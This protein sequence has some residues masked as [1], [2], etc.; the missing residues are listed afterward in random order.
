MARR[1]GSA[2]GSGSDSDR[3]RH[4]RFRLLAA[5]GQAVPQRVKERHLA[6]TGDEL[7]VRDITTAVDVISTDALE[8]DGTL[9]RDQTTML[10]GRARAGGEAVPRR[11][12]LASIRHAGAAQ[13]HAALAAAGPRCAGDYQVVERGRGS[14]N[15]AQAGQYGTSIPRMMV[16]AISSTSARK[17]CA[18]ARGC[19]AGT[20]R[21]A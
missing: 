2:S 3:A 9:A 21:V 17:A 4:H 1:P 15:A 11:I 18:A 10:L 16:R 12:R 19:G 13:Q 8:A 6:G 7:A 20:P 14:E 5:H